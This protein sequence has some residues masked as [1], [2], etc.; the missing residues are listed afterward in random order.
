MSHSSSDR[1]FAI[2]ATAAVV[3]GIVGG[4]LLLGSPMEQRRI[5]SDQQR[6]QNLYALSEEIHL[7]AMRS[8]DLG[9]PVTLPSG[10]SELSDTLRITDPISQ[11]PYTYRVLEGTQYELCATFA[12]DNSTQRLQQP[13]PPEQEFWRHPSGE[14][15]FQLDALEQAPYPSF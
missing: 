10:L 12:T 3:A 1:I 4:F 15:C 13:A 2:A 5:R 6:L 8:Q 7:E 14:H 11:E 9:N